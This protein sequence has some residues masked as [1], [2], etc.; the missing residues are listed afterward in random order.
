[1]FYKAKKVFGKICLVLSAI[2]FVLIMSFFAVF[3][4]TTAGVKIDKTKL[5]LG[6]EI[7]QTKVY[8][9]N[10][11]EFETEGVFDGKIYVKSEDIP[12]VVKS[13]FIAVEDKRFLKHNGVDYIRVFGA[14]LNNIKSKKFSQG[15]STITQQLAKNTHL[16][17]DKT[18]TRK[19][20]F[21]MIF[22]S[23]GLNFYIL[24]FLNNYIY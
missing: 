10:G 23:I 6:Q 2:F 4:K 16:N 1:M 17:N 14:V 3:I 18:L 24:I 12:K 9:K 15:A 19:L 11:I 21:T 20:P 8:D 5:A 7:N 13:A 22:W